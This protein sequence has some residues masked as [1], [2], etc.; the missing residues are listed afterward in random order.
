[1]QRT[2][3]GTSPPNRTEQG[4]EIT[5]TS[6]GQTMCVVQ[7]DYERGPGGVRERETRIE[8]LF[9]I[10]VAFEL[11]CRAISVIERGLDEA[12][13]RAPLGQVGKRRGSVDDG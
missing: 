4:F 2:T 5:G 3:F 7:N 8:E 6:L 9:P 1:M 10:R 11:R 13:H 12:E